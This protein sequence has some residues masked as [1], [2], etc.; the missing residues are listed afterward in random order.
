MNSYIE[1]WFKIIDEMENENTY[2]LAWGRSIIELCHNIESEE[3]SITLEFNQISEYFLKYY[4]NQTYFFKFYQ[5]P[6]KS[7]PR[8]QQITEQMIEYYQVQSESTMP[9][10]FD[11]AKPYFLKDQKR[12]N[13]YLNSISSTLRENVSWRFSKIDSD[14][15]H[16]YDLD[17]KRRT[18]KL[19]YEQY[20]IVKDH[21]FILS[22]L[23]NY[24][25]AQLLE[26]F[27]QCPRIALKV[28][29]LSEEQLRRKSL[30]EFRKV[31]LNQFPDGIVRDFYSGEIIDP[32]DISVDHVI[33]WS[34][35]YSDDIWN[36]VITSKSRNSSKSNNKTTLEI[37]DKLK[38]RNIEIEKLVPENYRNDLVEAKEHKFVDKFFFQF[39]N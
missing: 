22:Q 2:K 5:G 3:K 38:A 18:V 26:K 24:R 8:I 1:S 4:W 21:A 15:I 23:L 9:I 36:L 6:A 16:L 14:Q 25:W 32:K 34:Y 17:L 28:K 39:K 30:A 12:Y 11:Y 19:S 29:G 31:L 35:M 10:W 37:I 20:K 33:P 13:K 7:K 27:N